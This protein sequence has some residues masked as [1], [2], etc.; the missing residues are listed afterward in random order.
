MR[1]AGSIFLAPAADSASAAPTLPLRSAATGV[2]LGLAMAGWLGPYL[3]SSSGS[4]TT[5]FFREQDAVSLAVS[6]LVLLVAAT[7]P[8]RDWVI[9]WTEAAV[10]RPGAVATVAAA[11]ALVCA[12]AGSVLLMRGFPLSYD[13]VLAEFDAAI[14]REGKLVA[15]VASEWR[16]MASALV[17]FFR[18]PLPGDAWWVSTYL[19]G[20]AAL[21]AAMS[22]TIGEIWT[23]PLLVVIAVVAVYRIARRLWPERPDAAAVAALLL[24]ATPQVLVTAMTPYA[25]SAHLALN[26]VWLALF[27]RGGRTSHLAAVAVGF[28]ACGLHQVVFHPLFVAPFLVQLL[29]KGRWRLALFYGVAYAAIGV[30]WIAYWRLALAWSNVAPD[31]ATQAGPSMFVERVL[32]ILHWP[33]LDAADLIAKNL[34]RFV[35]W[36][37][38]LTLPLVAMA[39]AALRRGEGITRP[40]L[41]GVLLTVA[42]AFLL[43]PY[44]GHGWGYRYLHGL[45]GSLTLLAARGWIAAT[46][47][48]PARRRAVAMLAVLTCFTVVILLPWR[49]Y[50]VARFVWP[51]ADA[52]EAI[53]S[54]PAD[55]VVVDPSGVAFGADL[56][57]N[58]PFLRNR[59]I[60][61][62]LQGLDEAAVRSVCAG[63]RVALFDRRHG[64]AYGIRETAAPEPSPARP[65]LDAIG[66]AE[67]LPLPQGA[68]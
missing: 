6:G 36:E 40:L 21:R 34:L 30:F 58:D 5:L 42:A 37:N 20:N 19:P 31:L 10:G 8:V 35:A 14:L 27:L 7:I 17:S 18:L 1:R 53:R 67:P 62:G 24:A 11:S 48:V 3:L 4:L 33:T 60:V 56:V 15:A 25:M 61:L 12:L 2:A 16:P 54:A 43:M 46:R 22:L 9:A 45:I 65:I 39:A 23:G 44:Q 52:V 64:T 32:E 63:Y 28:L 47:D 55:V 38:P 59:P 29:G 41:A 66:C 68:R 51:Y 49:L 50:Q 57:R 26:M 13:E